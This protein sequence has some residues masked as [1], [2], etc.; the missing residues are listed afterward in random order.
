MD[1]LLVSG[2]KA[3]HFDGEDRFSL[4]PFFQCLKS[5][6]GECFKVHP[7]PPYFDPG[8]RPSH[9]TDGRNRSGSRA[10]HYFIQNDTGLFHQRVIVCQFG[11]PVHPLPLTTHQGLP[12]FVGIIDGNESP[13]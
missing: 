9:E 6:F 12:T 5:R 8:R 13:Q 2:A 10:T 11:I 7:L 1:T 3:T 4:V